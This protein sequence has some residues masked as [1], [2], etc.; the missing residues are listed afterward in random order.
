[1]IIVK[2]MGG[3]GNQMFQYAAAR[4]LASL[5]NTSVKLD[6]SFFGKDVP[7][8]LPRS[9]A[10]VPFA[11][12]AEPA[13]DQEIANLYEPQ[14]GTIKRFARLMNPCYRRIH[15]REQYFHFDSSILELTDNIY[16]DGYWQ[17]EKYFRDIDGIIRQDFKINTVLDSLNRQAIEEIEATESVSVHIRRSDYISNS[18]ASKILGACPIDYYQKAID[19]ITVRVCNPKFYIFSDDID[20]AIKNIKIQHPTTFVNNNSD[21]EHE[22]LRLMSLC[23]HNI[24][25]NSSFSWWGAWLNSNPD[26]IVIAPANWFKTTGYDTR[27]LLPKSWVQL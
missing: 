18:S 6:L 11:I 5:H 4:R 12:H 20:W 19:F 1:M 17:S 21:K 23:K 22:D 7:G 15:I 13:T 8:I 3:L 9:Y 27:D 16:L 26:K 10:L 24:I 2:L 25:A 14:A